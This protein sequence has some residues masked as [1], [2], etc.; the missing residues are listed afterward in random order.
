MM[1]YQKGR[2]A[3]S[4]RAK[5]YRH[6]TIESFLVLGQASW[7]IDILNEAGQQLR[8][9]GGPSTQYPAI[10]AQLDALPGIVPPADER[11]P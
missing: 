8:Q 9:L 4:L 5:G 11:Q 2:L 1:E 10:C 7:R 3:Q 6:F